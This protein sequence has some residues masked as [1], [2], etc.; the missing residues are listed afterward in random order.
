MK[1]DLKQTLHTFRSLVDVLTVLLAWIVS[2]WVRFYTV[3]PSPKGIPDFFMY[4]KLLPILVVLWF[5]VAKGLGFYKRSQG[6]RSA[7]LEALD[8][9]PT[10]ITLAGALVLVTYF[11]EEYRYSRAT[12]VLFASL[13]PGFLIAARSFFRKVLRRYQKN[14]A[15]KSVLYIGSGVSLRHANRIAFQED[16]SKIE[17]LGAMLVGDQE[18]LEDSKSYCRH[19]GIS[20][21]DKPKDWIAFLTN[22]KVDSVVFA[23]PHT[24]YSFL[25]RYL[26]VIADQVLDIKMIP[27][28]AKFARFSAGVEV[29]DGVPFIQV[30]ESP[31]LG[32]GRVYKR[33]LDVFGS[34]FAFVIFAPLFLIIP[35][36]IKLFSKGPVFYRQ[37]RM[38]LDGKTF[39]ILKFRSMPIDAE[40]QTGAVWAKEGDSRA[41]GFGALLR[42]SSLDELPQFINVLRGEMS[43]VGPRPERPVFVDQFRQSV[44]GYMLRHK[45]KAGITG[46]AQVNGW[47]GNTSIEK[48]IECDLFYIQRWSIFF[49]IQILL[50]TLFK[51][52]ISKNAY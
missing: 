37:E 14:I 40:A 8:I 3:F 30:H 31:L 51:G 52:F 48:R 36:L 5:L 16:L 35:C 46:W 43:L 1:N 24:H 42:K 32:V 34:L 15:G 29:V 12:L 10:C 2:Y 4:A 49:D 38:G 17:C 19:S 27:N 9:I 47:R 18:D 22:K 21:L 41:T 25:D 6:K 7:V 45:V 11:Y 50:A 23:L 13:T 26:P 39:E 28:I 44:P 20:V 33:A